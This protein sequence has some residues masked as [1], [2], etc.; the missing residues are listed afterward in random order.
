MV[1][2]HGGARRNSGR[3]KKVDRNQPSVA[4]FFNTP[5]T[6]PASSSQPATRTPAS[7]S[8]AQS[9]TTS[10]QNTRTPTTRTQTSTTTTTPNNDVDANVDNSMYKIGKKMAGSQNLI[11]QKKRLMTDAYLAESTRKIQQEGVFWDHPPSMVVK[12]IPNL[13]SCWM[14]FFQL[15]VFNWVPEAVLGS[16][17]KP[18]CP[19]CNKKLAKNGVKLEPRLVFGQ[20]QNYW[21]NSRQRYRCS[22]CED[23]NKVAKQ[24]GEPSII[25][26][27]NDSCEGVMKQIEET[28]PELA[29]I[30]P[31]HMQKKNAIDKKLMDLVMH[32]AV[33]GIDP[34]AMSESIASWHELEYQKRENEWGA[35]VDKK[36]NHQASAIQQPIRRDEIEKCPDYFSLKMG[37]CIPSGQWLIHMFCVIIKRMRPYLDSECVKRAKSCRILSMDASY[38]II[39]WMMMHGQNERVYN[40][41]ISGSN[42]YNEIPMQFFAT[43]DNHE[44]IGLNLEALK[45]HG[46]DP[47]LVF[48]D[49]PGRDEGLLKRIF[50]KLE[51]DD[52]NQVSEVPQD[53]TELSVEKEILYLTQ[54]DN[55]CMCLSKFREDIEEAA[56]SKTLAVKVAFDTGKM[57]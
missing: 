50:P 13:K 26:N 18:R 12:A 6:P 4:S 5:R 55:A 21:L 11:R 43:S 46:L 1:N 28:N 20:H 24:K 17:W 2:G 23:R 42:E 22:H 52:Q 30:F 51:S 31:C 7:S 56:K 14:E 25:W 15:P 37:G 44:E 38:K 47:H 27:F 53:L 39:K 48:T 10:T 32:S 35:N 45:A 33:K 8:Q 54:I 36:V 57:L 9:S 29:N 3:K 19:N 49:D 16:H 41:L 34:A 40:A